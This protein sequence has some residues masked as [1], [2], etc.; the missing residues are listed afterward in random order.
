MEREL[1]TAMGVPA[2]AADAILAA[3][4]EELTH[5]LAE[6]RAALPPALVG[7]PPL[8]PPGEPDACLTR[9]ML[10]RMSPEE[11]NRRWPAVR[12]AL[13]SVHNP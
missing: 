7:V 11:I 12:E 2:E 8:S 13:A 5:A 3:Q 1:L 6:E 10:R 4:A 9:D